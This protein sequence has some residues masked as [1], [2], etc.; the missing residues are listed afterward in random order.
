MTN[1][2]N[3]YGPINPL[4]YGV[5]TKNIINGLIENNI[6]NFSVLPIGPIHIEDPRE[7][8][9]IEGIINESSWDRSAASLAIWHEFDLTKFSGKKL[10]AFPI[11]ETTKFNQT[12]VSQL[13]QMDAICVASE[14]AKSVVID[15]IGTNVPVFVVPGAGNCTPN[16][17]VDD[18]KN[19]IFT[20]ISVGK[21]EK[22]K[23]HVE[24]LNAFKQAFSNAKV[25]HRLILHCYNPHL[26]QFD[27][28]IKNCLISLGYKIQNNT[29]NTAAIIA[30]CG[31]AL[32]SI[33][34]GF[35]PQ[36]QLQSLY[37]YAHIGVYP[38]K[39]EGWN[40]PLMESIQHGL[41]CI[42]TNYS[43][44]TEYLND[45]YKY[46]KDLLLNNFKLESAIDSVYFRGDRGEWAS[47]SIEELTEKLIYAENNYSKLL[48]SFSES[49][50]LIRENFTWSNSATKL[51]NIIKTI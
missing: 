45:N 36:D 29:T 25:E 8:Q 41:P 2:F 15:N 43:A 23:S 22:R 42:A 26:Q 19:N 1:L 31:N 32:V 10:I 39:G 47:P 5:F 27:K 20:F 51:L 40:L 7:K 50:N 18:S 9:L 33:P 14:W 13:S 11:F 37:K 3:L 28:H 48:Q 30:S 35:I 34:L 44:H 38:S 16:D 49:V 4:G 17:M 21:F 46:P 24:L 12:S 6:I